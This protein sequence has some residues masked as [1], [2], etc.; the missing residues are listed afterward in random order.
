MSATVSGMLPVTLPRFSAAAP[1]TTVQ[2]SSNPPQSA[3]WINGEGGD[4]LDFDLL[5]EYLLDDGGTTGPTQ[6]GMPQFDFRYER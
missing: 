6:A 4:G 2:G 1:N 5:A 3:A